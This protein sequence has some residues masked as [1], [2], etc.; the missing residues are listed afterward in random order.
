MAGKAEHDRVHFLR[1]RVRPWILRTHATHTYSH[2]VRFAYHVHMY[3]KYVSKLLWLS[4]NFRTLRTVY[5]YT[6]TSLDYYGR[7]N[8]IFHTLVR[9]IIV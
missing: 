2:V 8:Q 7:S 1:V 9:I 5:R 4:G 6:I 3:W